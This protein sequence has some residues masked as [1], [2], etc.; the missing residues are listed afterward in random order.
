MIF[1]PTEKI[2]RLVRLIYDNPELFDGSTN[3]GFGAYQLRCIRRYN[4]SFKLIY[5]YKELV[6][7]TGVTT[8]GYGAMK[9]H[10]LS[11]GDKIALRRVIKW[12]F[13][14]DGKKPDAIDRFIEAYK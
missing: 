14:N 4:H 3:T 8:T 9:E 6:L 13:D 7:G 10:K 5:I 12:W 2:Q 11:I 1:K